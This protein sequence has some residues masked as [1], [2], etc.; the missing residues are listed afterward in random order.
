MTYFADVLLHPLQGKPLVQVS[1]VDVSIFLD[2][3]TGKETKDTYAVV[4]GDDNNIMV[5]CLNKRSTVHLWA[6]VIVQTTSLNKNIDGVG[7][8]LV[9]WCP[10][11]EEEA[12][13]IRIRCL[14]S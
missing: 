14:A 4:Q 1:N 13:L 3:L 12:V 7:L 8:G 10:D 6:G 11:V 9:G 5:T 2:F